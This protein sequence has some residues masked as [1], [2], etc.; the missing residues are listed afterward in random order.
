MGFTKAVEEK[1]VRIRRIKESGENFAI[2]K[3]KRHRGWGATSVLPVLLPSWGC[4]CLSLILYMYMPERG[5]S[6]T[7]IGRRQG[8]SYIVNGQVLLLILFP[9]GE[10][11]RMTAMD[12]WGQILSCHQH[13]HLQTWP[14]Q[15]QPLQNP[16]GSWPFIWAHALME[17][18]KILWSS[19]STHTH[20]NC[21][22]SQRWWNILPGAAAAVRSSKL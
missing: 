8:G 6:R 14:F 19:L 22:H 12:V 21:L 13:W 7:Y 16:T 20:T 9:L 18:Q 2:H 15:F 10:T 5:N 4:S 3:R 1:Y 11:H 17:L